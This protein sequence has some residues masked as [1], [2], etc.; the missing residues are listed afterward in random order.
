MFQVAG[1]CEC[2]KGF[3]GFNCDQCASGYRQFPDCMPCPCDFRGILPSHD[4][5]G[6]CL[7]KSNV[8]GEFCNRCKLGFFGLTKENVEG[9]LPCFCSGIADECHAAK[10]TYSV[11]SPFL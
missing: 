3:S 5:E 2:K 6:D 9:C 4:C 7:C 8:A 10:L 11:V 1:A